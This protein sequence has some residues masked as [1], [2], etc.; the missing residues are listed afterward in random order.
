MKGDLEEF[1]GMALPFVSIIIPTYNRAYNVCSCLKNLAALRYPRERF[2]VILVDDG[3]CF[4]LEDQV[5]PFREKL[6]LVLLC[7]KHAGRAVALNT[8]AGKAK[9]D[10]FLFTDDDCRPAEDY[11]L[12]LARCFEAN[13]DCMFGGKT[14]NSA[15]KNIF[16]ETSILLL[17]YL[18]SYY[19][20]VP[21]QSLFVN[22]CN[23]A[24]PA[25]V[26][27]NIGGFSEAYRQTTAE[28]RD[29]CDRWLW[30][31]YRIVYASELVMFHRHPLTL[32]KF[33]R[34]HF[35]YGRGACVFH[36]V[37]MQERN[38]NVAV[39]GWS[40]Y[41][42]MLRYPIGRFPSGRAA[43]MVVLLIMSQIMN[44]AGFVWG[45]TQSRMAHKERT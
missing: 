33:L 16:S 4:P 38:K 28:D 42:G 24:V 13:P 5:A 35:K 11:L 3:G 37:R 43:L 9:G 25:R 44:A 23:M 36:E 45:K 2:E 31:G 10:L 19:N 14:R 30:H 40:F 22:G 20:D 17:S 34:Q 18:F 7:Q 29:L 6:N 32:P 26:F 41:A 8:G 27:L 15:E 21:N 12:N 39:E 1:A